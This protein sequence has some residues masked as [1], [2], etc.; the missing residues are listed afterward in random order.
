MAEDECRLGLVC[1]LTRAVNIKTSSSSRLVFG[2]GLTSI[3]GTFTQRCQCERRL[4]FRAAGEAHRKQRKALNP[5]FSIAHMREMR[6]LLSFCLLLFES[7]F[8]L[9]P[10]FYD[11]IHKV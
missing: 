9:V 5:V 11:V 10:I 2:K 6:V 4:T 7:W 1:P 3:D 8:G